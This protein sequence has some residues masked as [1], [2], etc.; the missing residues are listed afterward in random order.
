MTGL[1]QTCGFHLN[2]VAT[3]KLTVHGLAE[4]CNNHCFCN[5]L[6]QLGSLSWELQSFCR[7]TC[8]QRFCSV[9]PSLAAD[10]KI[11]KMCNR[12]STF[13]TILSISGDKT[14]FMASDIVFSADSNRSERSLSNKLYDC[15]MSFA[16]A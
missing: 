8:W 3:Q 13:R 4:Q 15:T 11:V 5:H 12:R 14:C 10:C 16:D 1:T 6:K 2:A 9:L 7:R